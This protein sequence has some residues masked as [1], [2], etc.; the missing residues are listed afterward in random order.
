MEEV[1][2]EV[3]LAQDE[4]SKEYWMRLFEKALEQSNTDYGQTRGLVVLFFS[5]EWHALLMHGE[6]SKKKL[7]V[8][9]ESIS[10][11]VTSVESHLFRY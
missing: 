6:I 1:R 4:M 11:I 7:R 3:P 10:E 8:G 2:S 5:E 9:L